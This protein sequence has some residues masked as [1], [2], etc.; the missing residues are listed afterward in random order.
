MWD[1]VRDAVI[2]TSLLFESKKMSAGKECGCYPHV[3][4]LGAL[5]DRS[6]LLPLL[7]ASGNDARKQPSC[8][9]G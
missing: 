5:S 2:S 1:V 4:P 6:A 7:C 3:C 9:G 8:G